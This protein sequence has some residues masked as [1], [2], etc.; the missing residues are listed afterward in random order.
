MVYTRVSVSTPVD[1]DPEEPEWD[2]FSPKTKTQVSIEPVVAQSRVVLFP[3]TMVDRVAVRSTLLAGAPTVTVTEEASV[4]TPLVQVM[5]YV[6]VT[7]GV[8][9]SE[10]ATPT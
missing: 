1:T 4:V 9:A 5:V 2:E 6:V 7:A 10:P 3:V 8:R